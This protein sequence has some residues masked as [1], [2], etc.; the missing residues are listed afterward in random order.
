MNAGGRKIGGHL[1]LEGGALTL[2]KTTIDNL[3]GKLN[4]RASE[5]E[6]E[7]FTLRRKNDFLTA[8]GKVDMSHGHNYSGTINVTV[9]SLADYW[10]IFD[11]PAENNPK[12]TQANIHGTIDSDTWTVHGG[13][14]LPGSSPL[15]FTGNFLL[16]IGADW[17]AFLASPLKITC[18]FPSIFLAKAPQVFHPGIFRD[19]ILSGNISLSGALQHPQITGEVQLVNGKLQNAPCNLTK[20]NGRVTF[21]EDHAS[22]DFLNAATT[23]VDLSFGGEIDF[24]DTNDLVIKI[25]AVTPIFDVTARPISCVSKIE[26]GPVAATLAPAIAELEFRGGLFHSN[27]T[28]SLKE[29]ISS[30]SSAALNLEETARKIP[31]CLARTSVGDETLLLGAPLRPEARHETVPSK[32]RTKRH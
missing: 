27:W 7:Q 28:I 19:G 24:H 29:R 6:I 26:V 13:I 18:D 16:P 4:L 21:G 8:Q 10:S 1:T 32:G 23:D 22:L 9:D 17:N 30:Q 2:F 5:L 25:I 11:I 14:G 15:N 20:A 3:S 31:F 12:Q